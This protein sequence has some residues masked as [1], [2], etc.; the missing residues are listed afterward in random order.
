MSGS[1]RF[2][3]RDFLPAE[4][5]RIRALIAHTDPPLSRTQLSQAVCAAL[6]WRKP[7]GGLGVAWISWTAEIA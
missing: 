4:L 3:G 1:L 7:D 6:D 5:D 2:C